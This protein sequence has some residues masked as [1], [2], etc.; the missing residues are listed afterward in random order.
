LIISTVLFIFTVFGSTI[1]IFEKKD[2]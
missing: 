2:Y 1:I